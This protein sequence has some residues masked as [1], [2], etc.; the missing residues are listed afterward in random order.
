MKKQELSAGGRKSLNVFMVATECRDLVKIG[1]LADVVRDLA[2]ALTTMGVRVRIIVPHYEIIDKATYYISDLTVEFGT[3]Q[4]PVQVYTYQLDLVPVYLIYN[5][6]FFGGQYGTVYIDSNKRGRGP[7]EDDAKRFAFFSIAALT[8]IEQEINLQPIDIIHC[9][10]WHTGTLL[11]LLKHDQRFRN[12]RRRLKTLFTVHNLDYQGVRPFQ[13][14]H[15][16]IHLSFRDWFPDL[17]GELIKKTVIGK[18]LHPGGEGLL[19]NP[20]RTG[21]N[22]ADRVNTVSPTYARE[23]TRPDDLSKNFIG[24]RGLESD[25]RIRSRKKELSGILN[26]LFYEHHD[27]S[28][29]DPPFDVHSKDW[30]QARQRHKE[31]FLKNFKKHIQDLEKR[32]KHKFKNSALVLSK[33]NFFESQDWINRPLVVAVTRAVEQKIGILL[34]KHGR[35]GNLIQNILKRDVGLIIIGNGALDEDLDGINLDPNAYFI[36]AF[37]PAFAH[38]LYISGDIFLMPSDFEPCG[39]SQLIAMRYGCLPLVHDIG[40]LHDTVQHLQTGFKYRGRD[41]KEARM[42]L[43]KTLDLALQSYNRHPKRWLI[44]QQQA[45][46]QRFGWENSS[47]EYIALYQG[48]QRRNRL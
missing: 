11:L 28:K 38:L 3:N 9:H 1:G 32:L 20:I 19:Y 41:R 14:F 21:I 8:L 2:Q 46:Q 33:L 27:P 30:P 16:P 44:M 48:M 45:M 29:L 23:I 37:D 34:E 17:Y 18:I 39:I 42:N 7:F 35:K 25:L 24:G 36:C 12:L 4:W 6:Y 15:N 13:I 31:A 5:D 43:L 22:L 47:A 10:D 26:G 40:G